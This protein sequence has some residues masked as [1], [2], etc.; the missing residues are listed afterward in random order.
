MPWLIAG[1]VALL[2]L[3][4][5][6]GPWLRRGAS[7]NH[8]EIHGEVVTSIQEIECA[9]PPERIAQ[10]Y[11]RR[12]ARLGGFL[13]WQTWFSESGSSVRFFLLPLIRFGALRR[14][15][16]RETLTIGNGLF[17]RHGGTL[18]FVRKGGHVRIELRGFKPRLV[19]LIYRWIQLPVHITTC[20]SFLAWL[21]RRSR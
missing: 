12:V 8:T 14:E 9:H 19:M 3:A 4:W 6:F 10:I 1:S 13:L 20:R 15:A 11:L 16:D 2:W 18:A 5:T 21:S 17:S 7:T